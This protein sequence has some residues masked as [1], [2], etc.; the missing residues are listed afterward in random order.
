M[1]GGP[2]VEAGACSSAFWEAFG[3]GSLGEEKL[4]CVY[5]ALA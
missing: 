3:G 1:A 4:V 5:Y 2:D